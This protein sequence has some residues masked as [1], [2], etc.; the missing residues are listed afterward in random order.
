MQ[1]RVGKVPKREMVIES[2]QQ[3]KC[4]AEIEAEVEAGSQ[5]A[6][7]SDAETKVILKVQFGKKKKKKKM[8]SDRPRILSVDFLSKS[9]FEEKLKRG[10]KGNGK[11]LLED[12][13]LQGAAC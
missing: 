11:E 2:P 3:Y 6:A 9:S 13:H 8:L 4:L 5:V 10:L 7:V 12:T 1:A